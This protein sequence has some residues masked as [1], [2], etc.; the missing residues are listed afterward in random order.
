MESFGLPERSLKILYYL[1]KRYK[2]IRKV[3]IYGSRSMGNYH[4][5]SDIDITLFT[6]PGFSDKDIGFLRDDLEV[7]DLPY[8]VDVSVYTELTN[9]NLIDHI[10][11]RGKIL[12]ERAA[13]PVLE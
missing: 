8:F 11:R 13:E 1:F 7:S 12:Y 2:Y 5:G 10:L 9:I 6:D 3:L 4:S